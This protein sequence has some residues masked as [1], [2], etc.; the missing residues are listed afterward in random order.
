MVDRLD[1]LRHNAVVRCNNENRNVC[2]LRA[3]CAHRCERLMTRRIEEDD[4]LALADDLICADV[5]GDSARLMRT[6]GGVADG[7][8]QRG[9]AVVDVTHDGDDRRTIFER[10]RIVL[11][12]RDQRRINIR[13]QFLRCHAEL[14]G[15]EGRR[16]VIDLLVDAHHNTHEHELLDD[17]RCRVAH[18]GRKILDGD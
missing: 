2:D 16:I 4:L 9:L 10:L 18:L 3:A 8:K 7:I 13:R 17:I 12:L 5:L 6:D 11:D 15:D 14:S 1:G